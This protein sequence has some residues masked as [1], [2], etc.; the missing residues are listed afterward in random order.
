M[1]EGEYLNCIREG[2]SEVLI[3]VKR[4][5]SGDIKTVETLDVD[6]SGI[7]SGVESIDWH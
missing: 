4:G 5:V 6:L 3:D 7:V 2:A 1:V